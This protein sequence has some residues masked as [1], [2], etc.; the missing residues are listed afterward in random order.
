MFTEISKVQ[1]IA[2]C[3]GSG[4]KVLQGVDADIYFTGLGNAF[5]TRFKFFYIL[6]RDLRSGICTCQAIDF[7]F[8][9]TMSENHMH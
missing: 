9:C 5:L 3:A 7:V 2:I 1:T 8:M 6:F 4:G